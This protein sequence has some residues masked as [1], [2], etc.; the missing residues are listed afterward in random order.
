MATATIK[1]HLINKFCC[2]FI[3]GISIAPDNNSIQLTKLACI[4]I[5]SVR[6]ITRSGGEA[7]ELITARICDA[8]LN[9]STV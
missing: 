3:I 9:V 8:K 7:R 5:R 6:T 4:H 1:Y 2:I